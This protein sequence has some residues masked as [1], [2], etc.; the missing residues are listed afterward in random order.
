MN[1]LDDEV[2]NALINIM[3]VSV[4]VYLATMLIV[5]TK[6]TI[7]NYPK[8]CKTFPSWIF[9]IIWLGIFVAYGIGIY[10]SYKEFDKNKD[11][12]RKQQLIYLFNVNM[13]LNLTW[14][15]V[16]WVCDCKMFSLVITFLILITIASQIY[17]IKKYLC[18]SNLFW[19]LVPYLIWM[20]VGGLYLPFVMNKDGK[21]NFGEIGENMNFDNL[22]GEKTV[23]ITALYA[24]DDEM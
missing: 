1:C 10:F 8:M 24:T 16:F 17:L 14:A 13:L 20:I 4:I 3:I 7:E 22:K 2:K 5:E 21:F 6:H 11:T 9:Y 18:D 23:E 19:W 12:I 15:I